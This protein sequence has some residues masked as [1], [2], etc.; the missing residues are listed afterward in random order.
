ME[1]RLTTAETKLSGIEAGANKITVDSSL[2]SSSTNPVQNQVIYNALS[3][4]ANTS[5]THSYLPLSGGTVNGSLSVNGAFINNGYTLQDAVIEQGTASDNTHWRK[6]ASGWAEC[7]GG[8]G[9]KNIANRHSGSNSW[10]GDVTLPISFNGIWV[11]EVTNSSPHT[12]GSGVF[13][14]GTAGVRAVTVGQT[15]KITL[16]YVNDTQMANECYLQF[17]VAGTYA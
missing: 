11:T 10:Y 14:K 17:Y 16:V 9:G 2:S 6:W 1:G 5:H 15:S 3:E 7:W 12:I 8:R 4:K 13:V